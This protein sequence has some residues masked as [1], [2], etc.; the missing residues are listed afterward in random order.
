MD[1]RRG[2]GGEHDGAEEAKRVDLKSRRPGSRQQ[3]VDAR[4]KDEDE[5]EG[6]WRRG[7]GCVGTLARVS[8]R[9]QPCLKKYLDVMRAEVARLEAHRAFLV[10]TRNKV[11]NFRVS[12]FGEPYRSDY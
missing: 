12:Q 6:P 11:Y 4:E 2:H 7:R 10:D 1:D 9:W 3:M 8:K 5:G